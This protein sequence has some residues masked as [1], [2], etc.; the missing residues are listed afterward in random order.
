MRAMRTV[1]V[2]A[3]TCTLPWQTEECRAGGSAAVEHPVYPVEQS[4]S[5]MKRLKGRVAPIMAMS[6]T[7]MVALVPD[8]NGF[9]F[10]GRVKALAE[11]AREA[12]LQF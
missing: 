3:V 7:E 1:L 11:A 8:R 5:G 4:E 12:G 6:E 10:H 2:L 9:R